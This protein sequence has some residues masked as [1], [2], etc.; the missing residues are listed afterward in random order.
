MEWEKKRKTPVGMIKETL[1][2]EG[3]KATVK[4]LP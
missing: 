4:D 3:V 2:R 1:N